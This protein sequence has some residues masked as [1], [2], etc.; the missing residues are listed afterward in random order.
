M[1]ALSGACYSPLSAALQSTRDPENHGL[2]A[3]PPDYKPAFV[4]NPSDRS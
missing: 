3:Y 2:L 4:S 1:R